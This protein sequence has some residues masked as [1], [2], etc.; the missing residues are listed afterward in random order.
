MARS[1]EF[2]DGFNAHIDDFFSE[3]ETIAAINGWTDTAMVAALRNYLTGPALCFYKISKKPGI[4]FEEIK[5]AL[6]DEFPAALDYAGMFYTACQNND[7]PLTA[8]IYRMLSLANN[9][10]ISDE[11]I[12]IRQSLIGMNKMF[13]G[14]FASQTYASL[15]DLKL[16]A[17]Q[18]ESVFNDQKHQEL[19]LP[20]KIT[21][22][23]ILSQGY[24]NQE[25]GDFQPQ[26]SVSLQ[27]SFS[28]PTNSR[29]NIS[30]APAVRFNLNHQ[31]EQPMGQATSTPRP[32]APQRFNPAA[33]TPPR[34]MTYNLRSQDPRRGNASP[35]SNLN[36]PRRQ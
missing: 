34:Q 10:K 13:K 19:V 8:Y 35:R 32:V 11:K 33:A 22:P 23:V 26:E 7:E 9:A 1:S 29:A 36:Y 5:K 24:N 12:I 30:R 20:V 27:D 2:F 15:A 31:M 16:A 4:K 28:T 6:L 3:F 21:S 14:S 17:S 18:F 25:R